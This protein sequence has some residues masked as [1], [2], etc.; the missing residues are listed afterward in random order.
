MDIERPFSFA[1]FK[2][3]H[4]MSFIPSAAFDPSL[5]KGSHLFIPAVSIGNVPQLTCDLIVHTLKLTRVGAIDSDAVIPVVGQREDSENGVSVP[6][7]VYQSG[8]HRLTVVQQ[9]APTLPGR[10]KEL[11]AALAAFIVSGQFEHVTLVASLDAARR[12]DAQISSVPFRVLGPQDIVKEI[13]AR[14]G[15]PEM[16]PDQA[17]SEEPSMSLLPSMPGG[18]MTRALYQQLTEASTVEVTLFSMFV[19]EGDNVQDSVAFANVLNSYYT[20]LPQ[21]G[22]SSWTPPKSWE[23]LFGTPYNKELYQ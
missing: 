15:V 1:F 11:V 21:D 18:G 22:S 5:L 4:E 8:D 16:E 9:R 23:Y 20:L 2:P 10:K 12:V 14:I 3:V 7:E 17:T 13:H 19:L 6:I